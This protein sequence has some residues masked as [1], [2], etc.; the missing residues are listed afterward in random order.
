V[1]KYSI[2]TI[3]FFAWKW[4]KEF[5]KTHPVD[6]IIDEAGGIPLLSPL[7]A[8]NTPIYFLIHHI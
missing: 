5:I 2:N 7:Y 8:K 6:I 4:Y 3:Y 1:R